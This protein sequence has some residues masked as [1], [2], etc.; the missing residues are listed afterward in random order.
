MIDRYTAFVKERHA[1]WERRYA[2][3]PQP[4]TDDPVIAGKK[5]CN[6]FRALDYGSQFVIKELLT[7]DPTDVLMRC[8]MYR[9]TNRPE[10]WQAF[11]ILHGRYPTLQDLA[12]DAIASTFHAYNGPKFSSAYR[13]QVGTKNKGMDKLDWVVRLSKELFLEQRYFPI[14]EALRASPA[15]LWGLLMR[16][17]RIGSFLAMQVV[18]DWNYSGFG[19]DEND[20]V[21]PGPGSTR[22]AEWITPGVDTVTTIHALKG[23]WD[24]HPDP[25]VVW[26]GNNRPHYLTLMDIQNTLCEFDK[27]MRYQGK[28]LKPYEPKNDLKYVDPVF[29]VGWTKGTAT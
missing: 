18:T 11:Y 15:A 19:G 25:P 24:S 22:G 12:T 17:P 29:P 8:F 21:A 7:G 5:F 3:L 20:F 4:W 6:M 14:N 26:L 2:G 9:L 16:A 27:Y 23:L 10:P 1:V 28:Q 13:L